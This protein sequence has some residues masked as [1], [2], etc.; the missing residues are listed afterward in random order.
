MSKDN[1]FT[2]LISGKKN[3]IPKEEEDLS[4]LNRRIEFGCEENIDL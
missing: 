4:P 3:I 2:N 1:S